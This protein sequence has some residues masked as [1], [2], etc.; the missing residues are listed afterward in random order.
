[1][2][3]EDLERFNE[4]SEKVIN[5]TDTPDEFREFEYLLDALNAC[6]D[7]NASQWQ[8]NDSA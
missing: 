1:M 2:H 6:E 5:N 4:L 7:P 8:A 3:Q